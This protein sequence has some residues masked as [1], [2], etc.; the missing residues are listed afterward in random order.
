MELVSDDISR[1]FTVHVEVKLFQND[2][3][4]KTVATVDPK[5]TVLTVVNQIMAHINLTAVEYVSTKL[6]SRCV[7]LNKSCYF[8]CFI[9]IEHDKQASRSMPVNSVTGRHP[10]WTSLGDAGACPGCTLVL[11]TDSMAC[12][13]MTISVSHSAI[14]GVERLVKYRISSVT[15]VRDLIHTA[16][17]REGLH[18]EV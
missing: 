13:K 16:C 2:F 11:H 9:G 1:R 4:L 17:R 15:T 8:S 12:P 6:E 3:I 18:P 14:N 7:K 5:E 10:L